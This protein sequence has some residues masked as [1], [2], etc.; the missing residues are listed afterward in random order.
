[1]QLLVVDPQIQRKKINAITGQL[2]IFLS[3]NEDAV[4][5]SCSVTQPL[6]RLES[7]LFIQ[8]SANCSFKQSNDAFLRQPQGLRISSYVSPLVISVTSV[9]V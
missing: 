7:G 2:P 8:L 5:F 6:Y 4:L 1:M 3:V 9:L